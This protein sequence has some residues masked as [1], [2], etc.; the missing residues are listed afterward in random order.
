MHGKFVQE[1]LT[2]TWHPLFHGVTSEDGRC[3]QYGDQTVQAW[4]STLPQITI[5]LSYTT[6]LSTKHAYIMP[7]VNWKWAQPQPSNGPMLSQSYMKMVSLLSRLF[8]SC[9]P[10]GIKVGGETIAITCVSSTNRYV[11]LKL[12]SANIHSCIHISVMNVR[13]SNMYYSLLY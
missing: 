6:H 11:Y 9:H 1:S 7:G 12:P 4:T 8:R 13:V 3:W 2:R 10:F 5:S